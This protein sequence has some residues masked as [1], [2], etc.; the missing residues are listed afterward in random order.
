MNCVPTCVKIKE[1]AEQIHIPERHPSYQKHQRQFWI[2]IFL[3]MIVA[4]LIVIA[5]AVLTWLA[6]FGIAGDSARWAA[7]STIWLIIP[8]M[9]FGLLFLVIVTGLIYFLTQ[10]MKAIPTYTIKAQQYS[11][12]VSGIIKRISD[13]GVKPIFFVEEF[14]AKIKAFFGR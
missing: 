11:Y 14:L 12:R 10:T 8:V 9:F 3:P 7:I 5:V 4:V 13:G 1:M 2:Q 6:T